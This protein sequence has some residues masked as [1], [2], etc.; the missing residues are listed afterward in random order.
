MQKYKIVRVNVIDT[1]GHLLSSDFEKLRQK[2]I[3]EMKAL[4]VGTEALTPAELF[5]ERQEDGGATYRTTLSD[6]SKWKDCEQTKEDLKNLPYLVLK[7]RFM[8]ENIKSDRVQ[9][10][11]AQLK[12]NRNTMRVLTKRFSH[13]K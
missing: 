9:Q 12:N 5:W 10:F 13:R 4:E 8:L 11:V 3:K 1:R 2:N 7:M 6:L